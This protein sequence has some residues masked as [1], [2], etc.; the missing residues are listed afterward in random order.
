MPTLTSPGV[1]VSV[2]DESMYSPAGQGTVPLVVVATAQDKTDPSTDAVAVGTTSAN[3]GKPFLVTSQR[4]LVTTFGE[5]SFKSVAGTQIHGDERNEYGLLSTYS[6]LGISNRAYVVR[7][8]VDLDQ[9]E[10]SSTAPQLTPNNGTYWLDVQNTDFGLFQGNA[11]AGTWDKITPTVLTDTPSSAASS[12]VGTNNKPKATYGATGDFVAVASVDPVV[13][14]EK[15]ASSTWDAVGSDSW[16]TAKSNANVYIQ[17]GTGTAP[18]VA[19]ND[20]WLKSTPAGQ[21]ASIVVKVY[22]SSTGAWETKTSNM[23]VNDDAA[24]AVEGAALTQ[25]DVYVQFDDDGDEDYANYIANNFVSASATI[26]AT[27][28]SKT[29]RETTPEIQYGLKIRGAGVSTVATGDASS[30]HAA[31]LTGTFKLNGQAITLSSSNLE[32]IV[33][34]INAEFGPGQTHAAAGITASIDYRS[35]TRQYLKITRTGGKEIYI[36]DG[37]GVTTSDLGFTD[38]K[39]TG[40]TAYYHKSLWSDLSYE[41]SAT[42]PTKDPVN[43]TLWYNSSQDADI[44]IAT[45]DGGTMKW[46][47]YANSKDRFD[48]NSVVSGGIKDLQIVS[49]EPTAQSDGTA[50]EDGDL[51]ID[52][53]E[54]DVYP[55]IYKWNNSDSEWNL[56]DNTDQSTADG[57]VFAD[58]V[59][60]P[61]G[62]DEDAQ[63]WGSA[64]S[65]FHSDAPDP[66]VYPE[67]ILL[68]NTRLSGYNVKKFVTNYTFDGTNNGDIWVTESGLKE[69][70]SPYMG[71]AA[72]R[73]VVVSAMQSA[74]VDNDD[75][76]AESRF[77]NLLSAP[78]YPELLDELVSLSTDRKQT[79]FVVADTPFRLAPDGTSVQNWA[80]NANN[81]A[82]NGEDGLITAS[83]YAAVYYPSGFATNLDGN[84]V[85]VPPSHIALRTLAYNDSV[86]FPWF[87][88]A[89]YTRGL[90]DNSTSVGF[91]NSEEEYQPV[92]LSEGQRDTLY[93]N[94]INPIAFIPNRGLVVFGQKTLSPTAT[95]MDRVNVSRLVVYLRYQLD[96][97]AKPFLFEPNDETTRRQVTDTFNR[98]MAGLVSQRALYDFLVVCDDS[99]NTPARIDRNELYIDIAIQPVKAIEFIYI[100]V[101]IKNTGEDLAG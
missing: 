8:D 48:A 83:P 74:L 68:F 91:I 88:P 79:A 36:Q 94:K 22:N 67:N 55:K 80:T 44:Y 33:S 95:A 63:D 17:P 96:L 97:L 59:G 3:A 21:G 71:R 54:L 62:A 76:R 2:T 16:S 57:V 1:S 39:S 99:N 19:D 37:S 61:A 24:T 89:G 41:A 32:N 53:N 28:Y 18:T 35:A 43:G 82:S 60:N 38:N 25:N 72:Q 84:E 81:A 23:Y 31:S 10:A 4:E 14:Y 101:R 78:G 77:F 26:E 73:R 50:L 15:T 20:I 46:L 13:V 30:L 64:Y 52:S 69:D 70:G 90:V 9:L 6:Y 49:E 65:N 87:A 47:A 85:V 7:A 5:P 100:P 98:F 58:A 86:A 75:I 11:S 34:L 42:A 56:L 93:A 27:S 51:W 66:A 29:Q 45:N 12:N 40:S 92:T